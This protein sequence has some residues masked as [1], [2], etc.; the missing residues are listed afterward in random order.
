MPTLAAAT[1][2]E[3]TPCRPLRLEHVKP[4]TPTRTPE[5][6]TTSTRSTVAAVFAKPPS[7]PTSTHIRVYEQSMRHRSTFE[8]F[9]A[10]TA[11]S[12][13]VGLK[14]TIQVTPAAFAIEHV[15]PETATPAARRSVKHAH[16]TTTKTPSTPAPVEKLRT[17]GPNGTP[18]KASIN[19][20]DH[21][22]R[23]SARL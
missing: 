16:A 19:R 6:P 15:T 7:T 11:P 1:P 2:L 4:A 20:F 13:V 23:R 17:S 21:D 5:P 18:S 14:V 12:P 22:A 3:L 8:E 9:T 10:T